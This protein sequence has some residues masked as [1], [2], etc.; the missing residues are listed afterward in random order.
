MTGGLAAPLVAAGAGTV[1]GGLGVGIP[2]I[3]CYLGALASSS[4]LISGLFGAYSRKMTGRRMHQY[5]REVND[6]SSLPAR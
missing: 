6:F 5:A 1:M 4:V 3:G 2:L